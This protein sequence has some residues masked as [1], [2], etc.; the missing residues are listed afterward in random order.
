MTAC[1]TKCCRSKFG[2]DGVCK[3]RLVLW[4]TLDS[5]GNSSEIVTDELNEMHIEDT[6]NEIND[7]PPL[8]VLVKDG[9]EHTYSKGFADAEAG[10]SADMGFLVVEVTVSLSR[11]S[12]CICKEISTWHRA[13]IG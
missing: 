5:Q 1:L 3:T 9:T 11:I 10:S 4:K 6:Y 8:K 12:K 13:T 2:Y 7:G